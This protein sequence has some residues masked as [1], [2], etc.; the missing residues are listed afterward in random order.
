MTLSVAVGGCS[1][2]VAELQNLAR[3]DVLVLDRALDAPLPLAVGRAAARRG[4]CTLSQ[5]GDRIALKITE[6]LAG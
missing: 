5:R 1:I 4:A 3:G 2:T 6:A